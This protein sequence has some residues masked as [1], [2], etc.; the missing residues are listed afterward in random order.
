MQIKKVENKIKYAPEYGKNAMSTI[1]CNLTP[2]ELDKNVNKSSVFRGNTWPY[3][4]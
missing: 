3:K 1:W 2:D 4:I